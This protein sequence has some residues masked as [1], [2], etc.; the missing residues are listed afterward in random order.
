MGC[1]YGS[2]IAVTRFPSGRELRIKVDLRGP[3]LVYIDVE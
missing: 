3:V 1:S 2:Y